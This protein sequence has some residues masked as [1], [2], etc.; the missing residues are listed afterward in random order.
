MRRRAQKPA[1]G[2]DLY[3]NGA[4]CGDRRLAGTRVNADWNQTGENQ[5]AELGG[6][7]G[8]TAVPGCTTVKLVAQT[9]LAGYRARAIGRSPPGAGFI[10]S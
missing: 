9:P 3:N 2:G 7:G 1:A 5:D 8:E 10:R 6:G 4:R